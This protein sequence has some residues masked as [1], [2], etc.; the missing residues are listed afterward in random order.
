MTSTTTILSGQQV[1]TIPLPQIKVGDRQRQVK[2]LERFEKGIA[3]LAASIKNI[4]LINPIVLDEHNNLLA[5]FRR[6]NA[7]MM[8]GEEEIPY[9][10][11]H[12]LSEIEQ[13]VIELDENLH[14][15]DLE[16]YE[17][18][19]AI[20]RIHELKKAQ[21]E[22]AG[23]EEWSTRDTERETG[24]EQ[25]RVVR[26]NQMAQAVEQDPTVT[27]K[28]KTRRAALDALKEKQK[29]EAREAT[30][31]LK[32]DG[33]LKGRKAEIIQ[34]DARTLIQE[35]AD[36]SFDAILTNL[37]FGVDMEFHKA[38]AH[39]TETRPYEDEEEANIDLVRGIIPDLYRVLKPDSWLL[40]FYDIRKLTFSNKQLELHQQ[41][42]PHLEGPGLKL[43]EDSMG[44]A[45]WLK[46]AG[47]SYVSLIPPIWIKL[48]K[49][50]GTVGNPRKGMV[51]SYEGCVYAAKGDAS[52]RWQ[53]RQ[54]F[55]VQN[56]PDHGDRV[57]PLQMPTELCTH[58]AGMFCMGG[59]TILDPF[60]GSGAFGI[61]ALN[62][63]CHFKGYE[64]DEEYARKGNMLLREHEL[65][66]GGGDAS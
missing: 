57:H 22:A 61:G 6:L 54:N 45:H 12:E 3:E 37:P 34:G 56:T 53:G 28:Y 47:F 51:S 7:F 50:Q 39:T 11:R 18:D 36:D 35:E 25:S 58:L 49:T 52:L 48:N 66:Q 63:Q 4:G 46:Q 2:N 59:Y 44:L 19:L 14:R 62:M 23:I 33:Q 15:V 42:S 65:H 24:I 55:W 21:A 30:I 32:E 43:L 10:Y 27:Q 8:L 40:A 64:L 9:L 26:A 5:G 16:W 20:A 29:T 60:A 17:R 13:Q 41:L 1:R 38:S 31:R